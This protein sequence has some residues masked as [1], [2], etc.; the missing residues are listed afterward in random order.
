MND[1]SC[2]FVCSSE[3]GWETSNVALQWTPLYGHPST[4]DTYDIVDNSE[5]PDCPSIYFNTLATS[6]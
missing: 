1:S 5:S 4:A 2:L 6:E 3:G